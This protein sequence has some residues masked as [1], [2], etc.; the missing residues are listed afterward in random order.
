MS[1]TSLRIAI[2]P[3]SFDPITYGHMDLVQRAAMEYD[4]V[5]L[6]VMINREKQYLFSLEQ[7]K[8]IAEAA[9]GHLA[10]VEV[11]SSE[12]M[13]WKLAEDLNACAIVKG[14]RN[15]TDLLYEE[16]MAEYNLAHNPNAKTIL[17]EARNDLLSISSTLVREKIAQGESLTDYLPAKAE[18]LLHQFL[19]QNSITF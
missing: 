3:G 15:Q 8:Q 10:N 4:K 18:R 5:Y 19:N 6:A 11:I 2:V 16:K 9:V 7:R 1:E 14:F 13:L 17:L 12:G